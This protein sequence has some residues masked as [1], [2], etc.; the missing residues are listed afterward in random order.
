M[1]NPVNNAFSS[2]VSVDA[3]GNLADGSSF[4]SGFSADGTLAIFF[5]TADNL[6]A[7][8][9]NLVTDIFIKNLV[10]GAV[11][12]VSTNGGGT[13][14]DNSSFNPAISSDGT[15]VVFDSTADNLISGDANG[16]SDIF[17][18][19]LTTGKI[20]PVSVDATGLVQGDGGSYQPI[21][22]PDG[23]KVA[24][25]SDADN[26]V[27]G[28]TNGS[29][30]IFVKDLTTGAVTRVSTSALG[31]QANDGSYAFSFSPDGSKIAFE[32]FASNLVSGD[33]NGYTDIFVKDLTIGT[34]TSGTITRI[35]TASDGGQSDNGSYAP[36]F[37]SDGTKVAFYSD[38]DNLVPGDTNGSTD[39][40]VKNLSTG[41][42]TL[43]STS[44]SGAQA[45][46]SSSAPVFSP[47]G[48]M[49]AFYSAAD[50][51]I[52]GDTNGATDVFL[53]NLSTGAIIRVSVDAAGGQTNGNSFNPLFS[54][55]GSKIGFSSNA[56][57]IVSGDTNGQTDVFF[58]SISSLDW[59]A[60][61]AP[62]ITAFATDS[63]TVGDHLTND[64]SL[65]I[66]GTAEAGSTVTLFENGVSVNAAL[67]DSGG[68]WSVADPNTLANGTTYQFTATATDASGNT[69]VLSLSYAVT[70]DTAPPAAPVITGATDDV[71]PVTGAVSNGG[72]TNDAMITFA[73][74]AQAGSAI[75]I[76]DT[77]ATTVVGSGVATGGV[78][79]ITTSALGQ[80]SH[81]LTAKATD[82][83]ANQSAASTAFQVTVDTVAPAAPVVSS[84]NDDIAPGIGPVSDNGSTND[85]TLTFVGTSEAGSAV[86]IYDTDGTTVVGSGIASGGSFSITTS[87]LGSGLHTLTTKA[88]DAAGNQGV[89]S[90]AFH[91]T[92][93]TSAPA[94]PLISGVTDDVLPVTGTVSNSGITNDAT[95]TFAGAAQASSTVK[96]YDTDG[97]TVVGTGVATGGSFT[98]T[99]STLSEGSHI[100]TARATDAAS[101]EGAASTPFSVT[102]DTVAPSTP[103]ISGVTDNVSP[104]TGSV[105]DSGAT[106]DTTLTFAGTAEVGGAVTIY[107]TDGTTIVGSG[108]ASGGVFFSITTSAL[109]QGSHTLTVRAT[110]AASNQSAASTAFHVT[111]DTSAPGAPVITGV[112]DDVLPTTGSVSDNGI[113]ND[114][115]LTVAG[116]AK[117][118]SAVTIYDT[119]GTTAVGSGVATGGSFTITT[120]ALG[121]GSH[122]LTARSTDAAGNQ[123]VASAAFHATIDTVAPAAPV[124]SSVSDDVAPITGAVL[125][126]GSTNDTTLTFVGTAE[127]GSAVTIYDT[128]GATVV[129][130]GIA[131]GGNFTITTSALGSGSHTLT[132]RA[133]DVAGNQ[134]GGSTAFHVTVDTVALPPV[135]GGLGNLNFDGSM[136]LAGGA[137]A[138]GLVALFDGGTSIGTTV[139]GG[140]GTWNF[141]TGPLTNSPHVFTATTTDVAGNLSTVS[142]SLQFGSTLPDTLIG[143]S[144]NDILS[145]GVEGDWAGQAYRLYEAT[146][147]RQP[148]PG[149]FDFWIGQL[150]SGMSLTAAASGFTGSPEF[151]STYGS[152]DDT[153]FVTLLYNN[154]LHRAPDPGGLSFWL[155]QI[156]TGESRSDV[157]LGFSE[158]PE[159]KGN[160]QAGVQ[161]YVHFVTPSEGNVLDGGA[162]TDTASYA[163]AHAGVTVNLGVSGPQETFRGGHRHAGQHREPDGLG[164][165]RHTDRRHHALR[166]KRRG[167]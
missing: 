111:I 152:L 121:Q 18:K 2:I 155:N 124:I 160:Q 46:G 73:G 5:S 62:T 3:L 145:G 29:S 134:S 58:R 118:G 133:T 69:G 52:V 13:Q 75:T 103:V 15:Q 90:T 11:T 116:T 137:E 96:I 31:V 99:T 85:T 71:L 78:F 45:D 122:T 67:A 161:D 136:N 53:K 70:V 24:F 16:S 153:Q 110:D 61:T 65:S 68:N 106:N 117:S 109:S 30:D 64:P 143:G 12:R 56:S 19:N 93:V 119:D 55:D 82:A 81:T 142:G 39:I 163:L 72:T 66:S 165:R 51:L 131:A 132:V 138:N 107:D 113:T 140:G 146:L 20:T 43:V 167:G 36:V 37:S 158:S 33:T 57:D 22:S 112:T 21:F 105:S 27:S 83:A 44:A 26:L 14:S 74:T 41:V 135:F 128:D 47:D 129:G 77:D 94:A 130:A 100:L 157:V 147:A 98:I 114:A 159:D 102:V 60:P 23:T 59:V 25:Y 156:S 49:V 48:T 84:V 76:Y 35:S 6:V 123:S 150:R 127:S 17:I 9:T 63:G 144:G 86:T 7:S 1:T 34:I 104:V 50:N 115:T 28:D 87:A 38:A 120:S 54:P 40:F 166:A 149:G 164:L 148:D 88:T 80:G 32:S 162:G 154:V 8:D 126:N 151:Q 101:N 125:D 108:V 92:I 141:S 95:L 97:T 10:T 4:F 42:I 91:V 89:A 139:A 79:S